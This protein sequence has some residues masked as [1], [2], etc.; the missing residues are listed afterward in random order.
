MRRRLLAAFL[1]LSPARSLQASSWVDPTFEEMADRAELIAVAEVTEGGEYK[2]TVRAIDVL[3]GTDP[4]KPF[5]VG[6]FNNENWPPQGIE[7]ES[8]ATGERMLLF[9]TVEKGV[10]EVPTPSTG[11]FRI[12]AGR[13]KGGWYSVSYPNRSPGVE[14]DLGVE[15]VRGYVLHRQSRPPTLAR[16]LIRERLT[17]A[18]VGEVND[19][20]DEE[21]ERN[22]WRLQWL[23]CAQ[24]AYGERDLVQPV[25]AA[26]ACPHDLVKTCAGRALGS[27]EPSPEVRAALGSL[28]LYPHSFV[29]AEAAGALLKGSFQKAEVVPLVVKALPGSLDFQGGPT[30]IMDPLR[31]T[32]A[33]GR[34]VM[35]RLLTG[36]DAA[37]EA[38]DELVKLIQD[39]G[40][41]GGVFE[42]LADHF[43]KHRSDAARARFLELYAR[44]PEEALPYSHRYL[45]REK[46]PASLEAVIR[47]LTGGD[48]TIG[49][50]D[51]LELFPLISPDER[52][53]EELVLHAL[54]KPQEEGDATVTAFCILVPTPAVDRALS[55]FPTEGMDED[56]LQALATA[57]EAVK[58]KLDPAVDPGKRLEA[59]LRLIRR[60]AGLTT[61]Y[62]VLDLA[63]STPSELRPRAV[64]GLRAGQDSLPSEQLKAVHALGGKL[65]PEEESRLNLILE[66]EGEGRR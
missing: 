58:L 38:H 50:G 66:W 26:A 34:E 57:R 59:W 56:E 25:L 53:L 63:R 62:L 1:L 20:Q 35:I 41:T 46:S 33:S 7:R 48:A 44:C 17:A 27:V 43:L 24:A 23:L 31:N 14:A 10:R 40:L 4:G 36:L 19:S 30:R 8:L 61:E 16:K 39:E 29:Q 21:N 37:K 64:E 18:A 12:Q 3:K 60:D 15:L 47:R 32:R 6:G 42:A 65:T 28:L 22:A 54:K 55:A 5:L 51:L 9:L 13:L 45:L 52:L 2:A 11:D 49:A